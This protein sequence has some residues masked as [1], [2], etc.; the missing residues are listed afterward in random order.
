MAVEQRYGGFNDNIQPMFCLVAALF[1]VRNMLF[2][3]IVIL[4]STNTLFM[5]FWHRCDKFGAVWSLE[6][7]DNAFLSI[8]KACPYS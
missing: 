2:V 6:Y 1:V 7:V 3:H 4:V 5:T 8:E